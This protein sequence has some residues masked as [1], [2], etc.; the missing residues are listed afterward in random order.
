MKLKY[1][2][3]FLF[4]TPIL[5]SET[6]KITFQNG[7]I[8]VQ[9]KDDSH[10]EAATINRNGS[11]R[12]RIL[13]RLQSLSE[14]LLPGNSSLRIEKNTV[15]EAKIVALEEKKENNFFPLL[16]E[17]STNFEIL[18]P[19]NHRPKIESPI[20]AVAING[21]EFTEGLNRGKRTF[22]R[23]KN[24]KA[25]Y[26]SKSTGSFE[27]LGSHLSSN[28]EP[29]GG[30]LPTRDTLDEYPSR[31]NA[32]QKEANAGVRLE[33]KINM[34]KFVFTEP[35]ILDQGLI[36]QGITNPG[37]HVSAGSAVTLADATGN[38]QLIVSVREGINIININSQLS[39][40]MISKELRVFINSELP[41]LT[42]KKSGN[43]RF[44]SR[45]RYEL[46]GV[47]DDLTPMDQIDLFIDQR[48]VGKFSAK[49]NFR[50]PVILKEGLNELT[51]TARDRSGNVFKEIE[52]LFLDTIK[53]QIVVLQPTTSGKIIDLAP[54]PP[55]DRKRPETFT[56]SG[57]V[58]DPQP[59]SG[60]EKVSINNVSVQLSPNGQFELP[61]KL[62]YGV[63]ELIFIAVDRAGNEQQ[64]SRGII[65][66]KGS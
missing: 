43:S 20:A 11:N 8:E 46:E 3:L 38:F 10:W 18:L 15:F 41:K 53:P 36:I 34:N 30:S 62:K 51:I 61:L 44:I 52:S 57:R 5:F 33:L 19:S 26:P 59:S 21:T 28:V 39:G 29:S 22:F 23:V 42:V 17:V 54:N 35:S 13:T 66:R 16:E 7:T 50:V 56:V 25:E 32:V 49:S 58:L 64:V 63:N 1:I 55:T 45:A 27:R 37:A 9:K 47:I 31:K 14:V 2:A 12:D 24:E 6:G 40:Q 48:L 4:L 60:L 65:V